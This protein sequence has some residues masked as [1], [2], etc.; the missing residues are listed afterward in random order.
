MGTL[1]GMGQSIVLAGCACLLLAG[2]RG[3]GKAPAGQNPADTAKVS[4]GATEA[5][6]TAERP[7][8]MVFVPSV[9]SEELAASAEELSKLI[10][11][12]LPGTGA[13]GD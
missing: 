7:L 13:G 1:R 10:D 8:T 4:P 3:G 11:T 6:G 12:L 2:C 5:V 9:N